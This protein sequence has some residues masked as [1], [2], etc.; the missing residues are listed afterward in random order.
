MH[1]SEPAPGWPRTILV[2]DDED[3]V[4]ELV[5]RSLQEGGYRVLE[6][7]HGAAAI[8]LLEREGPAVD[9]VICD[10][11]MPILG[12]REVADWMKEHC[13][14]LPL[15][16]ISGYPRAYLEAHHLYQPL[17]P[18]LRKPFLPSRLLEA[19][20]EALAHRH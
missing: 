3:L 18:M 17:V 16:F 1:R 14:G 4:R 9:L 5:A 20:E 6:A 8:G 15:L 13:D 7:S 2:V 12:G 11:V 19:V 10:L